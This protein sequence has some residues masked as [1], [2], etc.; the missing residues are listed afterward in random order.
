[1]QPSRRHVWENACFYDPDS[2]G[3]LQ[4]F[5]NSSGTDFLTA[6]LSYVL[7]ETCRIDSNLTVSLRSLEIRENAVQGI[8]G[9]EFPFLTL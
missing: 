5:K 4:T 9:F 2:R 1:M 7:D 8:L 3:S 6:F